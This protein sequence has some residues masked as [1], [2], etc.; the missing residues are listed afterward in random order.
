MPRRFCMRVYAGTVMEAVVRSPLLWQGRHPMRDMHTW[1]LTSCRATFS[2]RFRFWQ[3]GGDRVGLQTV[4]DYTLALDVD[5][6]VVA[7]RRTDLLRRHICRAARGAADCNDCENSAK[8]TAWFSP[9]S[10][11]CPRYL[12]WSEWLWR[13]IER[14]AAARY[15]A[16]FETD[17]DVRRSCRHAD[18]LAAPRSHP[19]RRPRCRHVVTA[20]FLISSSSP[21][22]L[23]HRDAGAGAQSAGRTGRQSQARYVH[24]PD[25]QLVD[26]RSPNRLAGFDDTGS[27]NAAFKPQGD[28]CRIINAAA[29]RV[30]GLDTMTPIDFLLHTGGDL[31]DDGQTNEIGPG[32]RH[33]RRRA[34]GQVR[35]GQAE[36]PGARTQQRRQGR[37]LRRRPAHAGTG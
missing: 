37:V 8:L 10:P 26:G 13:R 16:G 35:F 12:L 2:R 19:T 25:L 31:Y 23:P 34:D 27:T 29:V 24:L 14:A 32:A 5:V 20:G 15:D 7:L 30:D 28:E 18:G 6:A 36:R 22:L 4:V 17:A 9:A 3:V 11:W 1:L 33:P 21:K